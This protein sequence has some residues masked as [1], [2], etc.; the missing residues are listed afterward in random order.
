MRKSSI[1]DLRAVRSAYCAN[2]LTVV[3]PEN[4]SPKERVTL[5]DVLDTMRC[6]SKPKYFWAM[7]INGFNP[8]TR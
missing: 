2:C 4:Y 1:E 5:R 8:L 6:C 7:D 3:N